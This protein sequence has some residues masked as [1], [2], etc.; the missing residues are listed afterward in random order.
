MGSIDGEHA[1]EHPKLG[2]LRA[3]D[4]LASWIAH[5]LLHL[6]QL[7]GLHFAWN[8]RCLAPYSMA[9]AGNW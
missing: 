5:D 2:R 9:Y 7:A 4:L 3:G 6:R 8:A 1:H